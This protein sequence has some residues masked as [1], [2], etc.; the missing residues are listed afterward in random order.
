MKATILIDNVGS[1]ELMGEWGFSLHVEFSGRNF[2]LDTGASDRFLKNA[3]LLGINIGEVDFAILSHAH[4]DHTNGLAGFLSVNSKAPVFLSPAAEENCYA[5]LGIFRKYIGMPKGVTGMNSERIRRPEG[6]AQVCE[7]VYV[8]PHSTLGLSK[9]G[10]R[11]HLLV[12]RGCWCFPDDFSHEQTLVFR[13]E[14]GLV[15]MNSCSHAGPDVII[16]EVMNV[17]PGE[18]ISAY[19]GGLH[20]FR[21]SEREVNDVADKLSACRIDHIYTGHCTGEKAFNILQ[22]RFGDRITQFR[23]GMEITFV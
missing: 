7:G 1:G 18:H 23:C 13:T 15:L 3:E 17:F 8:V 20:L 22:T 12:K 10:R 4:Y 2:L 11:N 19:V 21:L 9:I 6:V 5:G 14:N 16:E